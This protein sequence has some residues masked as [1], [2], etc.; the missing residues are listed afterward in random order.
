MFRRFYPEQT[1]EM[2]KEFAEKILQTKPE[3]SAAA[4]QGFFLFYKDQPHE[5]M[6][7]IDKIMS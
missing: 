1:Q 2:A 6:K 5:M 7:N 3:I 4:V